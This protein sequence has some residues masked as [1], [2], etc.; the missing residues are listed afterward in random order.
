MSGKCKQNP[1]G[2]SFI[3]PQKDSV[4]TIVVATDYKILLQ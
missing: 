1:D 4:K 3:L 2:A